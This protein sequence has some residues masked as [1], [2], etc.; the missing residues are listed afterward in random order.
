MINMMGLVEDFVIHEAFT[1]GRSDMVNNTV[2]GCGMEPNME[3]I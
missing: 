2:F 3:K 1:L